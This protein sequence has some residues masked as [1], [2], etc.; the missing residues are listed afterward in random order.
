MLPF[1]IAIGTFLV[2]ARAGTVAV[3]GFDGYGASFEDTE[4][5]TQGIRD[6]FTQDGSLLPLSGTDISHGLTGTNAGDLQTARMRIAEARKLYQARQADAAL[7][8]LDEAI[9]LHYQA[10]S[11]VGRR[12]ELADAWY[13]KA[14]CLIALGRDDEAY[15]AFVE[16]TYLFPK[17]IKDRSTSMPQAA[18]DPAARAQ[19]TVETGRRR[20]RSTDSIRD[21]G[22]A[23]HVDYVVVGYIDDQRD[24]MARIYADGELVAEEHATASE[25]PAPPVDDAY[26]L[27]VT[28]LVKATRPPAPVARTTRPAAVKIP[29]PTSTGRTRP[30]EPRPDPAE[31]TDDREARERADA[32]EQA[33]KARVA[34]EAQE[35]EDERVAREKKAAAEKRAAADKRAA[36]D[37][38]QA[39]T[40]RA[41]RDTGTS[42]ASKKSV[43]THSAA[44]ADDTP[45]SVT[46]QWWFWTAIGA[47][48]GGL[49][50]VIG[51]ELVPAPTEEVAGAPAWSVAIED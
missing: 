13:L 47:G 5:V 2:P 38:R 18:I 26:S 22:L 49:G 39:R 36:D 40:E 17:Y 16:T 25:L 12:P 23:L 8:I 51:Y 41:T 21:I 4:T 3:L 50:A 14:L 48:V 30:A 15:D 35:E 20:I 45:Q 32:A 6:A 43:P 27:I 7:P 10:L 24:I 44:A 9:D 34:R 11:D 33:E 37:E 29:P 46:R 31:E 42:A 28:G 19:A 1:L